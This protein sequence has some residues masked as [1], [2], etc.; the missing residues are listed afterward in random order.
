[1]KKI[2]AEM[3]Q[4]LDGK[5]FDSPDEAK[6]HEI[7]VVNAGVRVSEARATR[8]VAK[9]YALY[10]MN[11]CGDQFEGKQHWHFGK[12]EVEQLLDL[13]YGHRSDGGPVDV[14][15]MIKEIGL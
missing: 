7:E 10:L 6:Q 8:K 13:I 9:L 5:L 4:T 1:M 11:E 14:N 2:V 15:A 12:C 3:Y